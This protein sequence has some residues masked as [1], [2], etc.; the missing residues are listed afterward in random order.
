LPAAVFEERKKGKEK[1]KVM[2]EEKSKG[3]LLPKAKASGK[4]LEGNWR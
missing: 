3:L 2:R 1:V 4:M